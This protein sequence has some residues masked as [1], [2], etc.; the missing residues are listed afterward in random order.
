M[1]PYDDV[2]GGSLHGLAQLLRRGHKDPLLGAPL[3]RAAAAKRKSTKRG[4]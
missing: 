4:E 1:L 3:R 2:L